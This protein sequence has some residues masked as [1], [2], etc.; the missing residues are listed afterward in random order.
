MIPHYFPKMPYDL[1]WWKYQTLCEFARAFPHLTAK[2][3]NF[4]K[5]FTGHHIKEVGVTDMMM[6][7]LK[8]LEAEGL[9]IF[10]DYPSEK[11]TGA[12]ME[13][14][15]VS[16]GNEEYFLR[17]YIQAKR[18]FSNEKSWKQ[19][20]YEHLFS[21][22]KIDH[23]K[24]IRQIVTLV[25]HASE[26][27]EGY[28]PLYAFYNYESACNRAADDGFRNVYGVNL[29]FGHFVM[30]FAQIEKKCREDKDNGKRKSA[31]IN[32]NIG[33]L[34]P[35]FFSLKDIFCRHHY[36]RIGIDPFRWPFVPLPILICDNLCEQREKII[37]GIVSNQDTDDYYS[38]DDIFKDD[39][40]DKSPD[41][42]K[43]ILDELIPNPKVA[44]KIPY[45]IM[46]TLHKR[47]NSEYFRHHSDA[48]KSFNRFEQGDSQEK[49]LQREGKKFNSRFK[50]TFVSPSV[51]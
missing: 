34:R 15:F 19:H 43:S 9:G 1:L 22:S 8:M 14:N 18:L 28:Y 48:L 50:I 13:W 32:D 5:S 42:R 26:L 33:L 41:E 36:Y 45:E 31:C 38:R 20:R 51:K 44:D 39:F 30:K 16:L 47:K 6:V 4:D 27:G 23:S 46:K 12:D 11:H 21:H 24:A 7:S 3:L 29:A 2:F 10:V 40:K 37:N 35:L 25:D 17:L 49:D